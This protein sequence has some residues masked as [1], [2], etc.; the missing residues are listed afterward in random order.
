[1]LVQQG[2]DVTLQKVRKGSFIVPRRQK[3]WSVDTSPSGIPIGIAWS[4][5]CLRNRGRTLQ[6]A[7]CPAETDDTA[8]QVERLLKKFAT[9]FVSFGAWTAGTLRPSY[10]MTTRLPTP[11]YWFSL[12]IV[13]LW[14]WRAS[15]FA[16]FQEQ[17]GTH[18]R[19]FHRCNTC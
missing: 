3:V 16:M 17:A 18:T 19:G 9:P 2:K 5:L 15:K 13:L 11:K 4:G 14:T 10:Q 1:M 7:F 6:H 8:G 12:P